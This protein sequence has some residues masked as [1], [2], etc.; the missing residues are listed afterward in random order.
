MMASGADSSVMRAFLPI[1]LASLLLLATFPA[2][3]YGTPGTLA[4]HKCW[5]DLSVEAQCAHADV[6]GDVADCQWNGY[7]QYY[8]RWDYKADLAVHA[9]NACATLNVGRLY[10]CTGI[11]LGP[12]EDPPGFCCPSAN[13]ASMWWVRGTFWVS[14]GQTEHT[15]PVTLC[16]RVHNGVTDEQCV[17]DTLRVPIPPQYQI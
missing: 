8:C 14:S 6:V 2:G 7:G 17:T 16:L 1:S 3:A 5:N 9:A 4:L 13:A 11:F 12:R 15:M 10:A